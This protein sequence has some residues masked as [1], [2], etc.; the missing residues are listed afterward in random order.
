MDSRSSLQVALDCYLSSINDIAKTI[1]AIYPEL[2]AP[3]REQLMR[4]QARLV[5]EANVK[6]LAE[7]RDSL[8]Q[9]LRSFTDQATHYTR[10]LTDELAGTLDMVARNEDSQS[11]RNVG[12]VTHL[13]DFIDQME[14]AVKIR[15][16]SSLAGQAAEL[17]G[18]AE[19]IEL[20]SRDA[21]TSLR[22]QIRE[23][24]QQL[25]EAKLLA[26]R[27][28][29]TG[30]SNR[31]EL[32]RQL[33]ARIESK[34]D[35]CILL[36]DLNGLGQVNNQ[37]GHLCGDSILRQLS[38]RLEGEVR[39][40][41]F[42]CRWGGDE[43]VV[44]LDCGLETAQSRSREIARCLNDHYQVLIDGHSVT[45]DVDVS[46]GVADYIP[47]EGTEHLFHR[48]DESMYRQKNSPPTG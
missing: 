45:V 29:L 37:Y 8:H 24:Q 44:I 9:I 10:T 40:S 18:F 17:R 30:L 11:V 35:F 23:F 48:V 26:S 42:V 25:R 41:D 7:S 13:V 38:A 1:A 3:Y 14:Q 28:A 33:A 36:F 15:D 31:R 21:L 2:G 32:D 12:Y 20:D 27:D 22:A 39:A 47:G 19:S 6:T 43:F 34:T 5:F 4:L 46:V 16:F